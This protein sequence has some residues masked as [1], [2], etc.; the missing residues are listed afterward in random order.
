LHPHGIKVRL[1]SGIVSR[2][3]ISSLD[4]IPLFLP[5]R[6]RTQT[7]GKEG[8]GEIFR[9]RYYFEIDP[10]VTASYVHT[11]RDMWEEEGKAKI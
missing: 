11:Y 3:K 4:K 7:G 9:C 6:E 5:V 2:V 1:T 10:E 8:S